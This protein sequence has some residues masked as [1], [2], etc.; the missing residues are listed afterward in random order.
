[1]SKLTLHFQMVPGYA[2]E[3]VTKS[4]VG[5]VKMID[6]PA[7]NP[8][9]GIRIIGRTF[10][11]DG[12]ANALIEEGRA[13]ARK[14]F[15]RW[16]PVYESRPYIYAWESPNEP[17]PM[18][19]ASF[20]Y[21][22]KEFLIEWS[23][24]M[25]ARGWK[26][27]GGNFSV[28]WPDVNTAKDVGAGIQ[29]CDYFGLHEYSAPAMWDSDSW[30]CL[31]YRR[32]VDEL[33]AAGFN[34]PPILIT[35]CGIDGGVLGEAAAKTGWK[36]YA[37]EDQY[38]EQLKWYDGELMK[39]E[40]VEAATIFTAGPN[41]DWVDFEVTQS[42]ADKLAA[43][44]VAT[45]NPEEPP[46]VDD[47]RALGIDV[48]KWQGNIDWNKVK[49]DGYSFVIIRA[50]G[51]NDDRTAV[52]KDPRFDEY[53]E[54]AKAAGFLV[55]AYHGLQ[56]GF[57]GQA[58]LFVESVGD[59]HLD[60]GYFCDLE[61]STLT[62]AKCAAHLN[63]V[64]E[65][66]VE[67]FGWPVRKYAKVYTSPGF[68]AGRDTSWGEGRDLWLAHWTDDESAVIVPEPW[69]E[70]EFWQNKVGDYGYVDGISTRIDLDKFKGTVEAL[71]KKYAPENGGGEMIEVID[72]NGVVVENGWVAA[73][74]RG[75]RLISAEPPEGEAVW[76]VKQLILDTGGSM[77][78]R[79]Y[80]KDEN[81]APIPGVAILEGW[82]DGE[83]LPDD[84]APRLSETV[85][86]QPDDADGEQ[87]PNRHYKLPSNFSGPDGYVE[88]LWGPG[89]FLNPDDPAH[90][91]WIM[92][93]GDKWYS[94]V[95]VVPGWWD[96]HIKYWVVFTKAVGDD[97]GEEPVEPPS[98][99]YSEIVVELRRMADA[100]EFM[101]EHWPY[102]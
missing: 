52:V 77:A 98:G 57:G 64:D 43:Y 26:T 28:G 74:A 27:V 38:I 70:W 94:D 88:W 92:P 37:S 72:V 62:D 58:L 55:G 50:S 102:K 30:Y 75:A 65:R 24:L 41:L 86:E 59:R 31:R 91:V 89:E 19:D 40:I 6:P 46:V 84:A 66:L 25:H 73:E 10:M 85:W 49:A 5:Y 1:M 18:W 17:H 90:W 60:L 78:F 56:D 68:M 67:R 51:P 14:W 42:L 80:A 47:E 16:L 39:D 34:V 11:P 35:E 9:P 36:T 22:L 54:G 87:Y 2:Q 29:A 69:D 48:S 79:V 81:G 15:D 96:E 33:E 20:R 44:I 7:E 3:F 82:R 95:L 53:Y 76:R 71:I 99:D 100:A 32:T 4:G 45:P 12:E 97:G 23:A 13:G 61:V 8:F 63:A 93:G 101:V 21:N 83:L